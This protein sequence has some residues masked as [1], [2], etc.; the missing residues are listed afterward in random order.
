[1]KIGDTFERKGVTYTITGVTE[2]HILVEPDNAKGTVKKLSKSN[3]IY[4]QIEKDLAEKKPAKKEAIEAE[5]E[6]V[7]TADLEEP[8]EEVVEAKA[9]PA[10]KEEVKK[11]EAPKA[12]KKEAKAEPEPEEEGLLD[13]SD[14]EYYKSGEAIA[15]LTE[16]TDKKQRLFVAVKNLYSRDENVAGLT[17][18]LLVAYVV[19]HNMKEAPYLEEFE[20]NYL[21]GKGK[22]QGYNVLIKEFYRVAQ[23][24]KLDK[25]DYTKLVLLLPENKSY[26]KI[27]SH[28]MLDPRGWG[29]N[30]SGIRSDI[31]E[32][33]AEQI[34]ASVDE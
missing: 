8:V 31:L 30:M 21:K 7:D 1:M 16:K 4:K 33:I 22:W 24:K 5:A 6:N 29:Y 27:A 12:T 9:K 17:A 19:S 10:K 25:S 15:I 3:E 13:M 28:I 2:N 23:T 32:G 18:L 11:E 34:M 20:A 26:A 14:E